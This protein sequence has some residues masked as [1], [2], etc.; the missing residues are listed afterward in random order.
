[1][2]IEAFSDNDTAYLNWIQKYP[3]GFVINLFKEN[4]SF[5][6]LH[7]SKCSLISQYNNNAKR[8]GFT[9]RQYMKVCA[10]STQELHDWVIQN[11]HQNVSFKK[12]AKCNPSD[13][14]NKFNKDN[15]IQAKESKYLPTRNDCEKAIEILR[16][17]KSKPFVSE[18]EVLNFIE[19][20]FKDKCP[21]HNNWREITRKNFESWFCR[22]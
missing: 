11:R 1:M 17:G 14:E 20:Q 18:N 6:T 16:N 7:T 9:E 2:A 13:N 3:K 19:T 4:N 10:D 15:D 12:C 21:L 8:G 5:F 22:K